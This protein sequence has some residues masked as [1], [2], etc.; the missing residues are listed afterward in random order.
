MSFR[1]IICIF[2]RCMAVLINHFFVVLSEYYISF[3]AILHYWCDPRVIFVLP[4]F[5]TSYAMAFGQRIMFY[6]C[7]RQVLHRFG[8]WITS[9]ICVWGGCWWSVCI[10][11]CAIYVLYM[12]DVIYPH[13][14]WISRINDTPHNIGGRDSRRG[15]GWLNTGW[16]YFGYAS[17]FGGFGK[18]SWMR[19]FF[20][21]LLKFSQFSFFKILVSIYMPLFRGC[22]FKIYKAMHW[23]KSRFC[24]IVFSICSRTQNTFA[25]SLS[26]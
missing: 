19:S 11:D 10:D 8:V 18:N 22:I 5:W 15:G 25:V 20:Y 6:K 23:N 17:N 16:C 26:C 3:S 4:T 9:I 14:S 21:D 13:E 24:E 12:G 1:Q 2:P 7:S